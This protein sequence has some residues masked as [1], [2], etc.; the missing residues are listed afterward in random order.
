MQISL[1]IALLFA[2]LACQTVLAQKKSDH[3][4]RAIDEK[5]RGL[6]ESTRKRVLA[7]QQAGMP[8]AA[9]AKKIQYEVGNQGTAR[10][11]LEKINVE[12]GK[13]AWA[14]QQR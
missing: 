1:L 7:M 2:I 14:T 4:S 8:Q 13:K 10:K 11:M 9:I 12:E 3:G 5:V 6:D